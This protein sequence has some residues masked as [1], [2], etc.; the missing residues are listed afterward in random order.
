MANGFSL[1]LPTCS[2]ASLATESHLLFPLECAGDKC[3]ITEESFWNPLHLH[4][5]VLMTRKPQM[6]KFSPQQT[7]ESFAYDRLLLLYGTATQ[8]LIPNSKHDAMS[9]F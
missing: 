8:N 7:T 2:I 1:P 5:T 6:P 3:F 4:K 9:I